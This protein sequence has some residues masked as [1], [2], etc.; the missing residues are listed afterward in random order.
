MRETK[1]ARFVLI[2]DCVYGIPGELFNIHKIN[3][4]KWNEIILI[5]SL[6]S[7][8][9]LMPFGGGVWNLKISPVHLVDHYKSRV[10]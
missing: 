5:W 8:L 3:V 6:K 7:F 9:A 1:W 4:L 2:K 10:G